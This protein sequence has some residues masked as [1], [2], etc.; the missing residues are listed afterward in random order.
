SWSALGTGTNNYVSAIAVSDSN[1]YVGGSFTV[2]GG[3]SSS[4]FGIYH[5]PDIVPSPVITSSTPDSGASNVA[6]NVPITIA[7]S[8][9]MDTT[10]FAFTMTPNPGG[11]TGSWNS[12]C[13][14]LYISH[15][16]FAYAVAETINI[17]YA[18][19]LSGKQLAGRRV[20]TFTTTSNQGPAI[21]IKSQPSDP[22]TAAG[23]YLVQAVIAD[24][25]KKTG[26][27]ITA[28]TLYYSVN[29]GPWW[30]L[31]P[32]GVSGDTFSFH[33]PAIDTGSID[34]CI[35]AWDNTGL[36]TMEP[37]FGY[38]TFHVDTIN[39]GVNGRPEARTFAL[40]L[41][42][43][44]PNPVTGG[45]TLIRFSLPEQADVK[46]EV[47]NVLGQKV[48]TLA[49][50]RL[51]KGFHSVNWNGSDGNGQKLSSGVYVYQLKALGKSLVKRM[52][53]IR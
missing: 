14:T 25:A 6:L 40:Q 42:P 45:R 12:G 46:L 24:P 52:T 21:S 36:T 8:K 28:D 15:N 27:S 7:F 44:S 43:A 9:P 47:F 30:A 3:K 20:I 10:S 39:T 1:I 26:K 51:E 19:D 16:P 29:S 34:Y 53:L 32:S 50:G 18:A 11:V 33:I 37:S 4:Y 35:K 17:S 23:P 48:A 49:E 5:D 13:D 22:Q 41:N 38:Y 31:G 2:A